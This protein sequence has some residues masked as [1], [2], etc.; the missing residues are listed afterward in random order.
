MQAGRFAVN[1][2]SAASERIFRRAIA[3]PGMEFLAAPAAQSPAG[4]KHPKRNRWPA[5]S[6]DVLATLPVPMV[7]QPGGEQ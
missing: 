5:P 4:Q 1:A 3:A 6:R 7:K 2:A